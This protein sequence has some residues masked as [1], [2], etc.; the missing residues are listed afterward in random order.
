MKK[1]ERAMLL[2][3]SILS[4]S[5][6]PL[7]AGNLPN[8]NNRLI[9]E[10]LEKIS[11]SKGDELSFEINSI[12]QDDLT[13]KGRVVDSN[14][15]PVSGAYI[16]VKGTKNGTVT[17]ENGNFSINQ[18]P[19][20][21]ILEIT[22]LGF[23][24]Q[25][26]ECKGRSLINITLKNS[27]TYLDEVVAVGYG[28]KKKSV[29]TGAISSLSSDELLKAKTANPINALSGRVSG[30]TLMPASGQPG[31]VPKL[32]IRGVGTNGDSNP[33][34]IVDGLP[35][36][37]MNS[38]N[39]NDIQ[40]MEI[41]KDATSTAIYGA[42]GANGVVLITT[43]QG[44][45]GK[46]SVTY[47]GYY[48]WSSA[49][50][51]TH[52]LNADE[53]CEI[54]PEFYKN[55]GVD[56][57]SSIISKP[58]GI[59]TDWIDAVLDTAPV[60][61]HNITA[62]L[63]SDKGSTLL[64]I[65]YL[66][67]NG[68]MGGNKSYFKRY[69]IRVNNAYDIN[70][71][72]SVGANI[73]YNYIDKNGV[74]G[75][76]NGWNPLQYA[77][78]MD[79]T[80]PIY[81]TDP[82]YTDNYGF[83]IS[84]A[85]FGRMWN[86]FSFIYIS[87]NGYN[88]T[89]HFYGNAYI[90]VRPLKNLVF[91]SDIGIDQTG[92]SSR[93]FSPIYAHNTNESSKNSVS[94]NSSDNSFWQW[95]N[96]LSYT[97]SFGKHNASILLGSTASRSQYEYMSAGR[98]NYPA[99]SFENKNFWYLSAGDVATM[100]NSGSA[101][102][103]HNLYSLFGRLSY[104]YN[105]KLMAE[106]VI[107]RDGSS[108]F[109]SKNQYGIFPGVSVGWTIS[110][111][112]FW[113][114]NNFD[115]FKLRASWGQNGNEAIDPFSFTSVIGNDNYYTLGTTSSRKIYPGSA[116][117]NLVNPDLKWETSEQ[118]D[119]GAD[120]IFCGG[121]I[122]SS[123]DYYNKKTKDLLMK[124]SVDLV[125]GNEAAYNNVGEMRNSGFEMQVSYNDTFGDFTISAS[126]NASY[127]KNEV[128]NTGE[129]PIEGGLWRTSTNITRMEEGHAIGYFLL[130]KTNGIFQNESDVQNYKSSNG[131]V[132]QPQAVPGDFKWQ[133]TND[134]GV[135]SADDRVDS[136]NP[137]PKW[138]LGLTLGAGWKGFDASILLRSKLDYKLYSAQLRSEG[139]GRANLPHFYMDRW[140]QEGMDNGIPRLSI[141]DPNL[142]FKRASDFYLSDASF[143]KIGNIELGYTLPEKLT[144]KVLISKAR[145]YVSMDNV[146]TFTNYP[147]MDPEVGAMEGN[148]LNTG[149]DYS[150]Y[151]QARTLRVG[152]SV[153]F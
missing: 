85:N 81:G 112:K 6:Y 139:Y 71:Y 29:V 80:T 87:A 86:P 52:M 79:P 54:T 13:V 57:P 89:K 110:K 144:Q 127:L 121:K 150:I 8:A 11:K 96:T 18:V 56:V 7:S 41:L 74:A 12:K 116:P 1:L 113:N 34:Y 105:E 129:G 145:L 125:L 102:P 101:S 30:V 64:S 4:F 95:E 152:I 92:G 21:S 37:D 67:Q 123:I 23:E 97:H 5:F 111:E 106:F 48:G 131:T 15:I 45:K 122:Q 53:Y 146:A 66:D 69:S 72:I 141:S 61:E 82:A 153:T 65:G 99:G 138:N 40:S 136:G 133:D 109:G 118:L 107:R 75:G 14:M 70:K 55:D 3:S 9:K 119:F 88:K 76:S 49:Q 151:P 130:Y 128:L 117:T 36:S 44:T 78:M 31:S 115:S 39:P 73:N 91:K 114:I 33:L 134:D 143:L 26:I 35:M 104:N 22:F 147:F 38:I 47:D 20:N 19:T 28:V 68:I 59:D 93:S 108:N 58:N 84:T 51:T 17:D 103:K 2:A 137:W 126:F 10:N 94:T 60:Q 25:D 83:G 50:S 140:T 90:K 46:S 42:R 100:T 148:V 43:K 24:T 124:P 32:I 98:D 27:A 16:V 132:I 63:G 62:T 77:Y 149:L 142:N 120:M 135:I